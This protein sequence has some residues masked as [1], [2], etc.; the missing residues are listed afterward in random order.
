MIQILREAI[1]LGR[2]FNR[3]FPCHSLLE[4]AIYQLKLP[5]AGGLDDGI[6]IVKIRDKGASQGIKMFRTHLFFVI[7]LLH[8]A[9]SASIS[10]FLKYK[11]TPSYQYMFTEQ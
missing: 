7:K 9:A 8:A 10:L 5:F 6:R 3:V 1:N 11:T 4:L 2:W